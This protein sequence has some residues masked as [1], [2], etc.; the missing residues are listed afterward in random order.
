MDAIELS[1]PL[2]KFTE[3][4]QI[5]AITI[6]NDNSVIVEPV[7]NEYAPVWEECDILWS[8][9]MRLVTAADIFFT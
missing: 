5:V 9:K 8:A 3:F 6:R 1:W 2:T 4:R 7:G